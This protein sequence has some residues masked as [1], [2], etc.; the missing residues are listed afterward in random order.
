MAEIHISPDAPYV[1]YSDMAGMH[2]TNSK[3]SA[4]VN[5]AVVIA[6]VS[7]IHP[8]RWNS[9]DGMRKVITYGASPS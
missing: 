9:V 5:E 8:S 4:S 1:V 6:K 3:F 7:K 2:M